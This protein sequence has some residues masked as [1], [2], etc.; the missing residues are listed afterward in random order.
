MK[1]VALY[2][3]AS[4]KKEAKKIGAMIVKERLAACANIVDKIQSVYWWKSKLEQGAESLLVL[5]TKQSLA[6]KAIKRI[7]AIHSYDCPCI[8]VLPIVGGNSAFLQW[9]ADET[10]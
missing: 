6:K 10:R 8:T 3:T 2:V 4:N 1:T 9:I 5:K 7:K